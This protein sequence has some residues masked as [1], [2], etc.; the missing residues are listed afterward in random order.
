M[1]G[2]CPASVYGSMHQT[3]TDHRRKHREPTTVTGQQFS[4]DAYSHSTVSYRRSKYCDLLTDLATGQVYPL[5]TKDR[6]SLD[7]CHQGTMLFV[8]HPS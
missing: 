4:L 1:E 2:V 6:S 5:Y 7:L 8:S 3:R